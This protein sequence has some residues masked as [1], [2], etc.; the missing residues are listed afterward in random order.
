[1]SFAPLLR[2]ARAWL[3]AP[4]D[5][6]LAA[7]VE[8][9]REV[10][11]V[12]PAER[13]ADWDRLLASLAR[14]HGE[15]RARAYVESMGR[16]CRMFARAAK[17]PRATPLEPFDAV[18]RLPG[19]GA[20]AR[21]S[22]TEHGIRRIVD[23]IWTPPIGWDDLRTPIPLG[24]ALA[25]ASARHAEGTRPARVTVRALVKSA[26]VLPMRGRR[27][28]RV[29]L[30]DENDKALTAQAFW[31]FL[32]HGV[33]SVAK[34]GSFVLCVGRFR[35]GTGKI[36]TV[37]PEIFADV[38]EARVVRARYMRLGPK[39]ATLRKAIGHA[40]ALGMA[41]DPVPSSIAAREAL[42]GVAPVLR[43]VH[44]AGPDLPSASAQ[45]AFIERLAWSEAFTRVWERLASES[46]QGSDAAAALPRRDDLT[47]SLERELGFAFTDDQRAAIREIAE[48]L[49]GKRPM[50]RLLLGD[51]GTG[52]TA[53]ALAAI[54]QGVAAGH[55]AAILA[56]TT[57]LAEQYLDAVAPLLRATGARVA[58]VA[59]GLTAAARREAEEALAGG[60]ADVAIG[61][62]AL[63]GR[64]VSIPK[65]ALVVVDEQQ[66]LGV[67]QRL[68]LVHKGER[69]HLLT[70][71]ATPIPRT[72]ALALRGELATSIL[73]ERPRGRPPVRT[74]LV[75]R[76]HFAD[77]MAR[78]RDACR[79]GER[80]FWVVPR[81][82]EDDDDEEEGELTTVARRAESVR[83]QLAA[84]M[85]TVLHGELSSAEKRAAMARFR[86]GDALVLV[87]TTVIEVGVD[88]PEAT[89]MV[90]EN[91][92]F[93]GLGQLHQL[94][95]RV[96]R[97]AAPGSCVL[98]HDEPLE[99][100]ARRR[101]VA[102]TEM[103]SGEDV[104]RADLEL[105]GAGDLGGTRQH[106][107]EED[108]VW[109]EPGAVYPWLTALESDARSILERDPALELPEHRVL[110]AF[111][112]RHAR[113]LSVREEAG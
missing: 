105:R 93:F 37:H 7:L 72:L 95:G 9:G 89:L 22:L 33:L 68:S 81:I 99:G 61:T 59:A 62:H 31:F 83:E 45:R 25:E 66:R 41:P 101:L 64:G 5:E 70:L 29:V 42:G 88:V 102:L 16:A 69:P 67:A 48:D 53:V 38:P 8:Q 24:D 97:G 109:L 28:V 13:R 15:E 36:T 54:A 43:A 12:V 27:C 63:L 34:P 91:A 52:K 46:R 75:G 108:L 107:A 32:A 2:I 85:V 4:D 51:V 92:E 35:K 106:G 10:A 20:S 17:A 96:G 98:L 50:R 82:E 39:G 21:E 56:P 112:E 1:M 40:L 11:D 47:A 80:V 71:S 30:A 77:V 26:S 55:Q 84:G 44:G 60:D 49:A 104:A 76:S 3:E 113:A 87:G 57:V 103:A 90:V 100:V 6:K 94:R 14:P 18:D 65:L 74:E 111:V 78:V 73:R 58:F 23:L 86:S 110:R 79:L 19:L